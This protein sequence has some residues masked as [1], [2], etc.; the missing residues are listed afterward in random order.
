MLIVLAVPAAP[1][2]PPDAHSNAAAN[3]RRNADALG[4]FD[5]TIMSGQVTLRPR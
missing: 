2:A 5:I 1:T 4:N 3:A